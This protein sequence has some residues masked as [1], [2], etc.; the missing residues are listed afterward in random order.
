MARLNFI[1]KETPEASRRHTAPLARSCERSAAQR[2]SLQAAASPHFTATVS[3]PGQKS[4]HRLRGS[5]AGTRLALLL[6]SFFVCPSQR[7]D[8]FPGGSVDREDSDV[9]MCR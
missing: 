2:D 7:H 4:T 5:G 3:V 8:S 6:L 9:T 1:V